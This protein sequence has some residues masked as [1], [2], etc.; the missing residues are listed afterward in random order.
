MTMGAYKSP[1]EAEQAL[2][3][4]AKRKMQLDAEDAQCR[5]EQAVATTQ[6]ADNDA[7]S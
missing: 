7:S 5:G 6:T 4:V 3:R 1:T 2:A